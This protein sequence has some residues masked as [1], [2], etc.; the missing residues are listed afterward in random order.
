MKILIP[1]GILLLV[2]T[3]G[4]C[5]INEKNLPVKFYLC[6]KGYT[7]CDLVA[8][9]KDRQSCETTREKWGWYCDQTD[10]SKISCKEKDSVIVDSYCK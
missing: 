7:N 5:S 6:Q 8:K 2:I 4:G 3:L 9:F 10:K 1:V